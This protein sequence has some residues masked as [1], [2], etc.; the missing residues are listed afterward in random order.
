[1]STWVLRGGNVGPRDDADVGPRDVDMSP[2][3]GVVKT[4]ICPCRELNYKSPVVL[5]VCQALY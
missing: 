5:P 3:D 4:E 2:G 1:M